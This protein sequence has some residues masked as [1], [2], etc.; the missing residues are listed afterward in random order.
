MLRQEFSEAGFVARAQCATKR[1]NFFFAP[2][3]TTGSRAGVG[4]LPKLAGFRGRAEGDPLPQLA[5][6]GAGQRV[7]KPLH[8]D[9]PPSTLPS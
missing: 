9:P 8:S 2:P 4:G 3:E 5:D 7:P 1:N 6:P